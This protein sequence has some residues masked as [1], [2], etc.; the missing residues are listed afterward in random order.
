MNCTDFELAVQVLLDDR[1]STL[2]PELREHAARCAACQK[3]WQEQL[4]LLQLVA[5]LARVEPPAGIVEAVLQAL[6]HEA[7]ARP[8]LVRADLASTAVSSASSSPARGAWVAVLSAAALVLLTVSLSQLTPPERAAPVIARSLPS[9]LPISPDVPS[10]FPTDAPPVS[11][12][13]VGILS[14][15]RSE[16][17]ELSQTTTNAWGQFSELSRAADHLTG[18]APETPADAAP[19]G[20]SASW[21]RLDR[22][23]SERAAQA[24]DFLWDAIPA[25]NAQSS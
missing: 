16:Y 22:P 13:L 6:R 9:T 1:Q 18:F 10:G 25:N 15:V 24:F 19:A 7:V 21:I 5:P 17:Q 2:S 23:V 12:R 20:E 4:S 3:V 14:G 8:V 11:E